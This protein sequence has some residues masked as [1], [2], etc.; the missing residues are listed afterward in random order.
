[1]LG[2]LIY[3][4]RRTASA[5]VYLHNELV[6]LAVSYSIWFDDGDCVGLTGRDC[7]TK[8]VVMIINA[9]KML[10]RNHECTGK[11]LTALSLPAKIPTAIKK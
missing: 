4:L 1:M 11:Q 9:D 5:S 7:R 2:D 3:L 10:Q 8:T 6:C